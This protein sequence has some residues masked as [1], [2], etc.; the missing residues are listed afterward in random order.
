M[1]GPLGSNS[2][3]D[4]AVSADV[5]LAAA[6]DFSAAQGNSTAGWDVTVRSSLLSTTNIVGRVFSYYLAMFTGGNGRPVFPTVYA[7]TDDGYRYSIDLR[8][9]DP[10]GWVTYGNQVGFLDSDGTT[11]LYHDAVSA[12]GGGGQLT[13]IQ[14]GVKF[15]V[16]KFPLFFEPPADLTLGALGIP[17]TPTAPTIGPVTFVGN[18]SGNTTTINSGGTFSYTSNVSGIFDIVISADG[19]NFDPTLPANRRLRGVKP[20]GAQTV[21]W[22]G[23]ANSG[24]AFQVGSYTFHASVH[25]GEYHFPFIDAENSTVGGP[26]VTLLNPIGGICPPWNGGCKGGFYDDR[27]Y[28]TVGGTIVQSGARSATP[29]A[30][31]TRRRPITQTRSSAMTPHPRSALSARTRVPTRTSPAQAASVTPRA[32]TCGLTRRR[33]PRAT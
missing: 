19:V 13:A 32:S 30:A 23:K 3:T 9:M 5:A 31:S 25:G 7:T 21:S 17:L 33:R 11:P 2:N 18:V 16:P 8:G 24:T 1:L 29:S 4:A 14:G 20:S 27:V 15:A 12:P 6:G 26:T 10:N 28:Q 22:D